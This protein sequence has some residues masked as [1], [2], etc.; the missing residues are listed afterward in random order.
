MLNSTVSHTV[1]VLGIT[2]CLLWGT[3]VAQSLKR[4]T[5]DF[6]SGHDLRVRE[7]E[8]LLGSMLTARRLL[9]ILSLPFAPAPPPIPS[10]AHS[11]SQIINEF[12]KKI[13]K[14][15]LAVRHV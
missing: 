11:L 1:Q 8:P 6:G 14:V 15:L 2:G 4:L 9:G 7:I 12:F 3:W 13:Q 10:P 5:L